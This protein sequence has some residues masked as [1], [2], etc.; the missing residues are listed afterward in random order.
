MKE[1]DALE[2]KK[3]FLLVLPLICVPFLVLL[4]WLMD[5]G[6]GTT[7][8]AAE[9]TGLNATLPNSGDSD[10]TGSKLDYYDEAE[11]DSLR[12]L[13]MVR[14]DPNYNLAGKSF[15]DSMDVY[16]L[17]TS[18]NFNSGQKSNEDKIL[19]R[20]EHLNNELRRPVENKD[21][22]SYSAPLRSDYGSNYAARQDLERLEKM[23]QRMNAPNEED[24][25]MKQLN[26]VMDK[27]L[28]LQHPE[29]V[30]QRSENYAAKKNGQVFAVRPKKEQVNISLVDNKSAMDYAKEYNNSANKKA[31]QFF[32]LDDDSEEE[33]EE[34]V[35]EAVVHEDQT[36]TTGS[37]I[38]FRL[39]RDI[40]VNGVPVQKDAF[41]TGVASLSGERL[42]VNIE[43]IRSGNSIFPVNLSVYDTD[44]LAGIYIPGTITREVMKQ[45]S[46]QTFQKLNLIGI[47]Q[48]IGAQA[49]SAGIELG[50]NLFSKK[51]RLVKVNLKAG[52]KVFL[53]DNKRKEE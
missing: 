25:E 34:N 42:E 47:D 22:Y 35:I 32:G 2:K 4:F 50:K 30:Q 45:N 19:D 44:G 29:R 3:K 40:T 41:V 23:M 39:S 20:L 11:K 5:G 52:Y 36:I 26:D 27:I 48:S 13:E 16:G 18:L 53:K 24:Q 31:N 17:N 28:D 46:D 12:W 38:R 10:Q 9:N 15:E 49:A 1:V 51:I 7:A 14:S 21:E 37:V 43:S 6:K 8:I 33:F